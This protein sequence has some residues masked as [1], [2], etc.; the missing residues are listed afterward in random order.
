[1][2][3]DDV[4]S[5]QDSQLDD[6]V[7]AAKNSVTVFFIP[8]NRADWNTAIAEGKAVY[9]SLTECCPAQPIAFVIWS[10]PADKING[11]LRD[12]RVKAWRT[13]CEGAYLAWLLARL[14][15]LGCDSG[16]KISLVGYSFGARIA[17]GA[18]HMWNGGYLAGTRL[19][20]GDI[21]RETRVRSV[22]VA[23][24]EHNYWLQPGSFHGQAY[25]RIDYAMNLYNACDQA[26]KRYR[27]VEKRGRPQALGYT[28]LAGR[29]C[30]EDGAERIREYNACCH[31]GKSHEL[32]N[33]LYDTKL[34]DLLTRYALWQEVD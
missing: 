1:M 32:Y 18:L 17:I 26:L 14:D 34:A 33:Y 19:P 15:A 9:K 11:I 21:A 25:D 10:W 5:W 30:F 2:K 27:I 3:C 22:W 4:N 20:E 7:Q 6:L 13:D 28:G 16:C 8:G 24:A 29:A 31:V 23:A 12:F